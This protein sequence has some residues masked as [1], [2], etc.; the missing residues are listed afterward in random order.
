MQGNSFQEAVEGVSSSVGEIRPKTVPTDVFHFVFVWERGNRALRVF[1]A[2]HFVEE[3][4]VGETA[5]DFDG[6][7]LK[8]G[9]VG[10]WWAC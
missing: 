5:T 2:E 8:G 10:L 3:D 9:E 1:S 4:E 7:F 6:G